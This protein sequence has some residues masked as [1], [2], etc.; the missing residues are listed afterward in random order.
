MS[1]LSLNTSSWLLCSANSLW[2]GFCWVY[3]CLFWDP[4]D[5]SPFFLVSCKSSYGRKIAG[6]VEKILSSVKNLWLGTYFFFAGI[7]GAPWRI[8]FLGLPGPL[9]HGRK[10]VWERNRSLHFDNS[11]RTWLA[12]SSLWIRWQIFMV[13]FSAGK[14]NVQ[15]FQWKFHWSPFGHCF[16][17]MFMNSNM[18]NCFNPLILHCCNFLMSIHRW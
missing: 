8:F 5:L 18:H 1:P 4:A 9:G 6:V 13:P 12:T 10:F 7:E 15:W 11:L 16:H 3:F 17:K 14:W 2:V